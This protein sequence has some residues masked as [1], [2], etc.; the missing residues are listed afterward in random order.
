MKRKLLKQYFGYDD[1]RE[2]QEVL[3][4]IGRAHV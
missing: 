3:I 1:F 2:G 4:E